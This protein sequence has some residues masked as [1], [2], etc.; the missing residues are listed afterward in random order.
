MTIQV[1]IHVSSQLPALPQFI[2]HRIDIFDKIKARRAAEI[3]GSFCC[4][5]PL[6]GTVC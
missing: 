4:C 3:A 1:L 2:Q 6:F 5:A